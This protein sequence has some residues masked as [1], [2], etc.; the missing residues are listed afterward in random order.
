MQRAYPEE[1]MMQSERSA[2]AP[3]ESTRNMDAHIIEYL[4]GRASLE[5]AVS[6]CVTALGPRPM[7]SIGVAHP[8]AEM[9]ARLDALQV[10]LGRLRA[11]PG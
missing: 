8:D 7:L 5:S 4:S 3:S 1:R 10:E 11:D 2:H 6:A 9:Q